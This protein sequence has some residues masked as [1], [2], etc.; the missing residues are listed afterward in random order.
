MPPTRHDRRVE[1]LPPHGRTSKRWRQLVTRLRRA[2][3]Y[4]SLDCSDVV[5]MYNGYSITTGDAGQDEVDERSRE[6][7]VVIRRPRNKGTWR[8]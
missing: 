6:P 8:H 3:W 7:E 1:Q 4:W 5:I 2:S